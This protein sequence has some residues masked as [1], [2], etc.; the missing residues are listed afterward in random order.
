MLGLGKAVTSFGG[1]QNSH[2]SISSAGMRG[3]Q[4]LETDPVSHVVVVLDTPC[5]PLVLVVVVL[6]ATV[7]RR[8]AQ[9]TSS[10]TGAKL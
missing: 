2:E 5:S 9:V 1:T 10:S 4:P 7:V 6:A 8:K 3:L